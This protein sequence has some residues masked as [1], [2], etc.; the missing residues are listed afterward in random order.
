V[1]PEP[2]GGLSNYDKLIKERIASKDKW[3]KWQ[4]R[5]G[6]DFEKARKYENSKVLTRKEKANVWET[7]LASY[8]A[9]NPFGTKDDALRQKARER[10]QYWGDEPVVV[11]EKKK[12]ALYVE[13]EPNGAS[14]RILNIKPTFMQGMELKPGKYHV[15][16][17]AS[18]YG[19]QRS[20]IALGDGEEKKIQVSLEKEDR[21][22]LERDRLAKEKARLA[23]ERKRIAEERRRLEEAK[24]RQMAR[25]SSKASVYKETK[26]PD[27]GK[28][29][30]AKLTPSFSLS[31]VWDFTYVAAKRKYTGTATIDNSGLSAIIR[32]KYVKDGQETCVEFPSSISFDG[33]KYRFTPKGGFKYLKRGKSKNYNPDYF[34][35]YKENRNKMRCSHTDKKVS[36]KEPVIMV[37]KSK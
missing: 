20:W 12:S 29:G 37:R 33:S 34:Y 5:M 16:V 7:F 35:C 9:E 23:A 31:G 11:P 28:Y 2:T 36:S 14:V 6:A 10:R 4:E 8:S 30:K 27:E 17:S 3:L 22:A 32:T 15:E 19:T 21:E 18:G 26:Y 13:T 24:K 25:I 1:P